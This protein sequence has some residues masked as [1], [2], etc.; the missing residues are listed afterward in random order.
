MTAT[1]PVTRDALLGGKVW[2]SQPVRGYRAGVDAVLLASAC[3]A[4]PGES[5]LELGC[6][7]GAAAL[8]LMA[9][10][11]GLAVTGVERQV[12]MAALARTNAAEAEAAFEVVTADLAA[13]PP[14]LRERSFA[15]VIF[16]P[17]Y[18]DRSASVASPDSAREA[19][20]GEET[21]LGTW[22]DVATK[23]LAPRG[24][25]T[26]IQRAERL[27]DILAGLGGLGL[28][29]IAVQP[30]VP[31]TGRPSSLV[32][33]RARKD[34]RAPFT[35]HAPLVLHAGSHHTSD[36]EDYTD[37]V[38]AVLRDGAALPGFGNATLA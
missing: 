19:A 9:R 25:L 22:L 12:E 7:V 33:V 5:V 26:L 27:P 3:P 6:G 23:R 1:P 14:T 28:G 13:L 34:G 8:C 29:S 16:N 30:L 38:R 24:W 17:P 2:I 37:A 36:G 4:R 35:L 20:M 18:F 10:V 21:P 31:R 11:P 15:H 32:L